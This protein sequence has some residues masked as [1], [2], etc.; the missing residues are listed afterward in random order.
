M[1][2]CPLSRSLKVV[3]V[4]KCMTESTAKVRR[5][6]ERRLRRSEVW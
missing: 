4:E 5:K 2:D 1:Y 6:L 3:S